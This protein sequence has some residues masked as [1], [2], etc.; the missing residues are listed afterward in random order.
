MNTFEKEYLESII[1]DNHQRM[2]TAL[3][4]ASDDELTLLAKKMSGNAQIII[5]YMHKRQALMRG[6]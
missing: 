3:L 1:E 4:K 5:S 6:D 2:L